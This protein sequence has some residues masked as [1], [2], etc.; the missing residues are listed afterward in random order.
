MECLGVEHKFSN[1]NY[2]GGGGG[3]KKLLKLWLRYRLLAIDKNL[4]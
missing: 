1:N 4:R 3:V 2:D